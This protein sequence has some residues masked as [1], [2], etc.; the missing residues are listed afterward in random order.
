MNKKELEIWA[1]K[2]LAFYN[3]TAPL[4]DLSFW[5]F[6][7]P[8]DF[9]N[10]CE[11][12]LIGLNPGGGWDFASQYENEI[13]KFKG[14]EMTLD[15]FIGGNPCLGNSSTWPIMRGLSQIGL[16]LK[17]LDSKHWQYINYLPFSTHNVNQLYIKAKKLKEE[18]GMDVI[19]ECLNL[20]AEY[21]R[22]LSPMKI[23]V[24]GTAN[25]IDKFPD[26]GE[27]QILLSGK[28]RYVVKTALCGIPTIAIAHPSFPN[29]PKEAKQKMSEM[30]QLY[31]DNRENEIEPVRI[32]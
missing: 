31:F 11:L 21:I 14:K 8:A 9:D 16:D 2:A 1:G 29:W 4:V 18:T 13:W 17:T 19:G 27:R 10:E 22:L 30:I 25:G 24:M 6:Q 3:K 26:I 28:K 20:T 15:T 5:Q 32:G 7:K 12:L 23:I